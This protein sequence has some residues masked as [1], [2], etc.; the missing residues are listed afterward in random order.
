MLQNACPEHSVN[1]KHSQSISQGVTGH[2]YHLNSYF[3]QLYRR[4]AKKFKHQMRNPC[5]PV[6]NV[7][8]WPSISIFSISYSCFSGFNHNTIQYQLF[9][10]LLY[11]LTSGQTTSVK[12]TENKY[13]PI[14]HEMNQSSIQR[15]CRL[16]EQP[17]ILFQYSNLRRT[18]PSLHIQTLN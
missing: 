15:E 7:I 9:E 2:L 4:K 10:I 13:P 12:S 11:N 3:F 17:H 14:A 1:H 5:G 16:L 8:V 6:F 18:T